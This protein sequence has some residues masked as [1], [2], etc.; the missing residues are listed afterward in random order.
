[1]S[2]ISLDETISESIG[3]L[4]GGKSLPSCLQVKFAYGL[5]RGFG[6]RRV[7]INQIVSCE[8]VGLAKLCYEGA[9]NSFYTT[10]VDKKGVE[11]RVFEKLP[12]GSHVSDCLKNFGQDALNWYKDASGQPIKLVDMHKGCIINPDL[13]KCEKYFNTNDNNPTLQTTNRINIVEGALNEA[14]LVYANE[15]S[16]NG[17]IKS[18]EQAKEFVEEEKFY[19]YTNL[20]ELCSNQTAG[21][22]Q[23]ETNEEISQ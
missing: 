19:L 10:K 20:K 6:Y 23:E 17:Y 15:M 12:E 5:L 11:Q 22:L 1:M 21:S 8:D 3:I 13:N 9:L 4:K 16:K 14:I 2:K 7:N 18:R